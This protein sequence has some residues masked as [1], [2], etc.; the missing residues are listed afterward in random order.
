MQEMAD[1]EER[2]VSLNGDS[3]ILSV[4]RI[5]FTFQKNNKK[6]LGIAPNIA[7]ILGS[8]LENFDY[9]TSGIYLSLC[10][11]SLRAVLHGARRTTRR[12]PA[13]ES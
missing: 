3:L 1:F 12:S 7:T 11:H 5:V 8:F 4:H 10:N 13:N 6:T 9:F 2:K